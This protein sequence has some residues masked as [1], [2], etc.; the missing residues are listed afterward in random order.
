MF[1][2]VF[3]CE[4]FNAAQ[5]NLMLLVVI[6]ASQEGDEKREKYER[7]VEKARNINEYSRRD[8]RYTLQTCTPSTTTCVHAKS[9]RLKKRFNTSNTRLRQKLN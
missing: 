2:E 9:M 6:L 4:L 8:L 5:I 1:V 7:N 3:Q